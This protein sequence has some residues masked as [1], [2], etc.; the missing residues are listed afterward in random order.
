VIAFL[1]NSTKVVFFVRWP[2]MAI[3]GLGGLAL[4]FVPFQDRPLETWLLSF[5]KSIYSPT[6]YTYKKRADKNW[7]EWQAKNK[8]TTESVEISEEEVAIKSEGRNRLKDFVHSLPVKKKKEEKVKEKLE[9]EKAVKKEK[10]TTVEVSTRVKE[11]GMV[12][13]EVKAE[14]DWRGKETN[15]DLKR[16]KLEA[17]GEVVF[18]S[19][20]MPSIPDIANLVVGMVTDVDGKIIENAIVE[21]QNEK[22]TPV[23]VLKTNSLGQFRI[24]TPLANGRYL[25]ITEKEGIGFDRVNVS[26][27]GEIVQ[28]VKI[29]A[30][31]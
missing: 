5:I 11:D 30:V 4:A 15:L 3:F 19:I 6:I 8:D 24:S 9:A 13:Q 20:P 23:R 27:T 17:T 2:L 16:Q 14:P 10:K 25:I 1:I 29:R 12:E 22:G 31:T 28:P 21:V 18:G 7:M 26:L